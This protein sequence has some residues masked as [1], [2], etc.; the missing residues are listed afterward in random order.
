MWKLWA[1]LGLVVAI[2]VLLFVVFV[3]MLIPVTPVV[4]P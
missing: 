3:P 2:M 4:K 1:A